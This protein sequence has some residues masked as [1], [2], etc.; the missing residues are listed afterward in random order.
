MIRINL[1]N[2][3]LYHDDPADLS[4]L[5]HM[6]LITGLGQWLGALNYLAQRNNR[7]VSKTIHGWR[8]DPYVHK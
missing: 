6:P 8:S 7:S 4:F 3:S 2:S 1:R 5:L